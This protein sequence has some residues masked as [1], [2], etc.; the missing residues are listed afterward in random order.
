MDGLANMSFDLE[1]ELL[2]QIKDRFE[3][4]VNRVSTSRQIAL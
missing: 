3:D 2:I 1:D 4:D